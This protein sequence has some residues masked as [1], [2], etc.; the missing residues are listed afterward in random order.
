MPKKPSYEELEKRIRQLEHA[1]AE[2]KDTDEILQ[3]REK[4]LS[5]ILEGSEER[6]IESKRNVAIVQAL[7]DL[8]FRLSRDG[9]HL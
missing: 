5:N 3:K 4:K 9:V 2:K 7:P 1:V 8:I 6:Q